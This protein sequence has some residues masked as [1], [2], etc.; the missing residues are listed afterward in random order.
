MNFPNVHIS[1]YVY[2][3]FI[4]FHSMIPILECVSCT[5][6]G[7]IAY[8]SFDNALKNYFGVHDE[9]KLTYRLSLIKQT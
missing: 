4:S 5:K 8:I 1:G 2:P 7:K 3:Y 6:F 9:E